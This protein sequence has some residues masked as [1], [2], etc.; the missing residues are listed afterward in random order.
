MFLGSIPGKVHEYENLIKISMCC[1]YRDH[2]NLIKI[3]M[4]YL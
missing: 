4:C 2:E 1:L 3:S